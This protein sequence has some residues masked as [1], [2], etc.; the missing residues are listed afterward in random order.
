[1]WDERYSCIS[2]LN[3]TGR[4]MR[5]LLRAGSFQLKKGGRHGYVS[6][7]KSVR[8]ASN[9]HFLCGKKWIG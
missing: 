4:V 8:F 9:G 3:I 7:K 1:M 6:I 5:S 2:A